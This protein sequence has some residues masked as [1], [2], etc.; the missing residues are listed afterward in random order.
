MR[1]ERRGEEAARQGVEK[2]SSVH[3]QALTWPH[4]LGGT[5]RGGQQQP[6]YSR[7]TCRSQAGQPPGEAN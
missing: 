5:G 6:Y 2:R 1:G 3:H 4:R 7:V